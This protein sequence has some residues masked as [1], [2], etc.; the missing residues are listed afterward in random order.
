MEDKKRNNEVVPVTINNAYCFVGHLMTQDMYK[1]K[2]SGNSVA[3][4]I[5]QESCDKLVEACK[6]VAEARNVPFLKK[7]GD[8]YPLGI[9]QA[10]DKDKNPKEGFYTVTLKV[11]SGGCKTFKPEGKSVKE[12]QITEEVSKQVMDIRGFVRGAAGDKPGLAFSATQICIKGPRFKGP[13]W[14]DDGFG[15]PV[16]DS[17]AGPT[18]AI[19]EDSGDYSDSLQ[20]SCDLPVEF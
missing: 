18:D 4:E 6:A 2:P 10:L 16:G 12:V 3:V 5:D 20:D 8:P 1:G 13:D 17:G 15:S 14:G 9:K 7:E 11:A 19:S